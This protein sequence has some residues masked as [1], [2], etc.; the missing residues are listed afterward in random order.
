MAIARH[1]VNRQPRVVTFQGFRISFIDIP[2]RMGIMRAYSLADLLQASPADASVKQEI[3]RRR[4]RTPGKPQ[5]IYA[6]P[7]SYMTK[8]ID[9]GGEQFGYDV[10]AENVVLTQLFTA[11]LKSPTSSEGQ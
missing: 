10:P 3:L 11:F 8:F 4:E 6:F 9:E 5:R 1:R 7:L 2:T